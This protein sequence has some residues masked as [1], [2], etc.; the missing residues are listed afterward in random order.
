MRFWLEMGLIALSDHWKWAVGAATVLLMV[1]IGTLF[2][3]VLRSDTAEAGPAPSAIL[4]P[5]AIPDQVST[6]IPTSPPDVVSTRSPTA[7][8]T[9]SPQAADPV[10][11]ASTVNVPIYLTGAKNVGSLEFVLAYDP[12]VLEVSEVEAGGLA[13]N[14]LFDF[15]VRVPGR[16]WA[17]LID[18]DGINGDGPVAVVSFKVIGPGSSTS[19]LTLENVSTYDARS[20]LDILTDAT[21]GNFTVDGPTLTSPVLAFPR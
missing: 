21:S 1:V 6:P 19:R 5:T 20:L 16:L 4:E 9:L 17:G 12:T 10:V 8:P 18:T 13:Q 3:G 11:L 7:V 2:L 14:S 15:G